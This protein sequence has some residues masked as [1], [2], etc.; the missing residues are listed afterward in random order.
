MAIT[1]GQTKSKGNIVLPYI[2]GTSD[3]LKRVF[4]KRNISVSFK[5][6]KTIRQILVHPKDKPDKKDICGPIYHIKCDGHENQECSKDY[7]GETERNLKARFM[8]H[9]RPSSTSSE[10]S[11]HIH[12]CNPGHGISLDNV[13]ILDREPAWFDRGVK[14]AIYI[15]TLKPALNRDGGRYQLSHI[16]D[17]SLTSLTS[18]ISGVNGPTQ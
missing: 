14:E 2:Q 18:P 7:I 5:P 6:H 11:R 17:R 9:R 15:R 10:V 3:Q 16:W 13:K 4:L 12:D 1:P 8:E